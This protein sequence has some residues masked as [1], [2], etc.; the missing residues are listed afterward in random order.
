MS[1]GPII[2][3]A[4]TAGKLSEMH[5]PHWICIDDIPDIPD[6]FA[7][8]HIDDCGDFVEKVS[9]VTPTHV[10]L[11]ELT[12]FPRAVALKLGSPVK[13]SC[14]V[15]IYYKPNT[16]FLKLRVYLIPNDPA[17]QQKMDK[18]E[19]CSGYEKITKLRPEK[20]LK[21]HHG[22]SLTADT[23]S[24]QIQPQKITLRND[25][26]DPNFYEVY[27]E[28]P[29]RCFNLKLQYALSKKHE[30]VYE[31][32]WTCELRKDDHPKS[33]Y[34]EDKHSVDKLPAVTQKVSVSMP[35]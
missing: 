14:N 15:L 18:Q 25:S 27:I 7:V 4:V 17:L 6:R 10:K 22:F 5:L 26:Q 21:M 33:G 34:G 20:H 16:P 12:F 13:I 8:L 24:A 1:A 9:E 35:V 23:D 28:N 19:S 32:V 3:V 30:Q 31:P 2:D 29:E 11:N